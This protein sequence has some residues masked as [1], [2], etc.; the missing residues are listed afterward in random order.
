MHR[1]RSG[2][3]AWLFHDGRQYISLLHGAVL[4]QAILLCVHW[5]EQAYKLHHICSRYIC[6]HGKC[7]HSLP[8]PE[9]SCE[10]EIIIILLPSSTCLWCVIIKLPTVRFCSFLL[11]VR[12]RYLLDNLTKLFCR[13]LHY[14]LCVYIS[15]GSTKA[16]I[17]TFFVCKKSK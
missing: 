3:A 9:T 1:S 4:V 5:I 8:G 2:A 12:W 6:I 14:T 15:G 10:I 11:F 16:I 7:T 13:L 17:M